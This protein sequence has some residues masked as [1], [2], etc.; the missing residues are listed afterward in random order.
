MSIGENIKKIRKDKM[1]QVE[2]A[3]KL[4][5]SESMIRKYESDSVTPSID[6]LNKMSE[7]LE[8]SIYDLIQGDN[9]I[10]LKKDGT[11]IINVAI[12]SKEDRCN[13]LES[14]NFYQEFL[15]LENIK[16]MEK[17]VPELDLFIS[18]HKD[19]V[20]ITKTILPLIS[21]I[22]KS[23]ID[24]NNLNSEL[25]KLFENIHSLI[26]NYDCT[27][28]SWKKTLSYQND[29]INNL[30]EKIDSVNKIINPKNK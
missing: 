26:K 18:Y 14:E 1:T 21:S 12:M 16:A 19:Y 29:I 20:K 24:D 3:A 4:G 5:K 7:I 22:K 15:T 17:V 9:K 25:E 2:L 13:F 27:F 30:N 28:K 23:S 6:I 8:V 10:K 11:P